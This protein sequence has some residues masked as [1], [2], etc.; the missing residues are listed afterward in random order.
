MTP[1]D[2]YKHVTGLKPF[3]RDSATQA[4][5]V[6]RDV[7]N[8]GCTHEALEHTNA[9]NAA[10]AKRLDDALAAAAA[11]LPEAP[12][13]AAAVEAAADDMACCDECFV[14]R[15]VDGETRPAAAAS[16]ECAHVGK[17]CFL[18]ACD[19]CHELV[20]QCEA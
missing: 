17:R 4:P 3:D 15:D 6:P 16:F 2:A 5:L 9:F 12:V 20:C 10:L 13:A 8:G 14:W 11:Q 19:F 7:A 18:D 1:N